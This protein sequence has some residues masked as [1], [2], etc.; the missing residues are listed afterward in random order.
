MKPKLVTKSI[1]RWAAV[2][3][4]VPKRDPSVHFLFDGGLPALFLTRRKARIYIAHRYGYI[5]DRKDLRIEPHCWRVPM[6]VKVR[7][8]LEEL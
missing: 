1:E 6:A 7:V 5:R 3:R 2:W 8:T 4:S